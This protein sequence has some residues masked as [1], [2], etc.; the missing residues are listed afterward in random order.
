V[1]TPESVSIP[2]YRPTAEKLDAQRL[3]DQLRAT[4]FVEAIS[5][6]PQPIPKSRENVRI[7]GNTFLPGPEDEIAFSGAADV[8][9][10]QQMTIDS[11]TIS[12]K[13][14]SSY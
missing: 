5:V 10:D 4:S 7:V 8:Q 13:V 12:Q 9:P 14:A 6:E 1:E 3:V 2:E 11:S